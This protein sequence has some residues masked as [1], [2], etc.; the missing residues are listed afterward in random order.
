MK[1]FLLHSYKTR[2]ACGLR[3]VYYVRKRKGADLLI[4][5]DPDAYRIGVAM[6]DSTGEYL[7]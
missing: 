7:C 6:K 2:G 5:T 1:I 3:I 4:A